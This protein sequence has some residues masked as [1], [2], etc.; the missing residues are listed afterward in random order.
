MKTI[1]LEVIA[2][3]RDLDKYSQVA[4]EF[5]KTF[6][7]QKKDLKCEVKKY[8]GSQLFGWYMGIHYPGL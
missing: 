6:E 2:V 8:E 3:E 4:K 7:S 5:S 1:K